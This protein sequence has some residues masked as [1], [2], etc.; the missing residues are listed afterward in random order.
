M[1]WKR[2]FEVKGGKSRP[3]GHWKT[4][5]EVNGGK[6]SPRGHERI[7]L[8]SRVERAAHSDTEESG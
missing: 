8:R 4:Q 6:S 3:Q 5:V 2:Q 7:R 1:T